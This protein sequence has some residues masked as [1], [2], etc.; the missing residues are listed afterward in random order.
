MASTS[1]KHNADGLTVHGKGKVKGGGMVATHLDHRIAMAFLTM[2]LGERDHAV[3]VDDT[4]MIATS[5][6]AYLD[7][8]RSLDAEFA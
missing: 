1:M 7:L 3:T 4:A 5:F 8:M 2:E 6:P